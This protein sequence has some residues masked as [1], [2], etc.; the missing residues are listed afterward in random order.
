MEQ[1]NLTLAC[2]G[3]LIFLLGL[4]SARLEHMAFSATLASLI[5]GIVLGPAVLGVFDVSVLQR[6][7]EVLEDLAR[8]TLAVALAGVAMRIPRGYAVRYWRPMSLLVVLAMPLMWIIS[9]ALVFLFLDLGLLRSALVAAIVTPTDPVASAAVVTGAPGLKHIPERLRHAIS[10]ESGANDGLAYPFVLLPLLLLTR[11]EA[12]AWSEWLTKVWL[13]EIGLAVL[14]APVMGYTAAKLI[15]WAQEKKTILESWRCVYVL[16]VAFFSAG[17]GGLIGCNEILLVFLTCLVFSQVVSD[18]E[19]IDHGATI[20]AVNRYFSIPIFAVIGMLI[21]WEGWRALG[22]RGAGMIVALL[23]L[24]RMPVLLLLRPM[25][26]NVRS[27]PDALLMG[28]FGPVAV[29]AL[30]YTAL[31]EQRLADPRIWHVA[32]L[33]ICASALVHGISAA[34]LTNLYGRHSER[35]KRRESGKPASSE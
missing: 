17:A 14:L 20:E 15:L 34:P 10:L 8:I 33:V 30:Y 22:W 18:K 9:T 31:V 35:A 23:L 12:D 24:R 16:S 32:S 7:P 19:S 29:A 13:Y 4:A 2:L 6:E 26:G 21:P 11:G 25:I 3:G 5:A 1:F 28:W 27:I